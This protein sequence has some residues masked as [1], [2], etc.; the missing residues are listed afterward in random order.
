M[1]PRRAN[2]P[3]EF[4][5]HFRGAIRKLSATSSATTTMQI[6]V[7][8]GIPAGVEAFRLARRVLEAEGITPEPVP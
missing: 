3:Q 8:A 6:A 7:Y 4:K 5:S 1:H 2:R